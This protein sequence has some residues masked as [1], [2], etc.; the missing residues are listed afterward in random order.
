MIN[1]L[2]ELPS[3]NINHSLCILQLVRSFCL[4]LYEYVKYSF[5]ETNYIYKADCLSDHP[6]RYQYL[7][8]EISQDNEKHIIKTR[9]EFIKFHLEL[10]KEINKQ[11]ETKLINK[12]KSELQSNLFT[13]DNKKYNQLNIDGM[14]NN[15][16]LKSEDNLVSRGGSI[17]EREEEEDNSKVNFNEKAKSLMNRRKSTGGGSM[18]V[19]PIPTKSDLFSNIPN[20]K[21]EPE[22]EIISSK[23]PPSNSSENLERKL[24]QEL[25]ND[26]SSE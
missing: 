14:V 4:Q 15:Y 9:D 6:S 17:Y 7:F 2:V 19:P 20:N 25:I 12:L 1:I 10:I 5:I 26:F 18:P 24:Q 21:K 3:D 22:H 13:G 8:A 23:P 16:S 11:K